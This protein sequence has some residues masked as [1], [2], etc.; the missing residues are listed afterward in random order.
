MRLYG[1]EQHY[2]AALEKAR[3][4]DGAYLANGI[5]RGVAGEIDGERCHGLRP[6]E[7]NGKLTET[8][9]PRVLRTQAAAVCLELCQPQARLVYLWERRAFAQQRQ[10]S[11]H[12]IGE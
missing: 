10:L 12:L 5:F 1:T 9:A 6:R 3:S 4:P 11:L 8:T 2:E 7:Q